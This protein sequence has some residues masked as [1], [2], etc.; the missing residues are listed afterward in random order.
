MKKA[1]KWIWGAIATASTIQ[2]AAIFLGAVIALVAAGYATL[3][4]GFRIALGVALFGFA[5]SL[6]LALIPLLPASIRR[7]QQQNQPPPTSAATLIATPQTQAA[8]LQRRHDEAVQQEREQERIVS[9]RR[10][11]REVREELRDNRR[12]VQRAGDGETDTIH[13][14]TASQWEL[15]EQ[16]LLDIDDSAPHVAAREAYRELSGIE[17]TQYTR[18]PSNPRVMT[19][20]DFPSELL[21]TDVQTTLEAIDNAI[22]ALDQAEAE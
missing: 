12:R 15:Y 10:A 13:D 16:T 17:G 14:L 4:T 21:E 11:I 8:L 1:G 7:K 3:S 22:R 5:A 6:L 20:R 18:D 2:F 19:P 9:V